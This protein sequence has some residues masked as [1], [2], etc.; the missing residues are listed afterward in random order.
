MRRQGGGT[1]AMGGTDENT[2]HRR[3]SPDA[4]GTAVREVAAGFVVAGRAAVG[5]GPGPGR[6][7]PAGAWTFSLTVSTAPSAVVSL[8]WNVPVCASV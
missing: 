7:A 4:G 5:R 8:S 3:P 2:L 1:V 6:Y